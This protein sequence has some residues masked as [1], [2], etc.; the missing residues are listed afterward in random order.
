[1]THAEVIRVVIVDDHPVVREGLRAMLETDSGFDVVGDVGNAVDALRMIEIEHPHVVLT[2][3]RMPEVN[4]CELARRVSALDPDVKVLV[5]TTYD[6]GEDILQAI[7]VGACGYLL[8][9]TPRKVLRDSIRAAARGETVLSPAVASKL[10]SRLRQPPA[11]L[12][13]RETEVL[14]S[15]SSGNTNASIGRQLCISEATVKTHLQHV[16]AK[17]GVDDRTAAV[18]KALQLGLLG[19]PRSGQ[20]S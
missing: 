12:S 5:L 19:D 7:E 14:R 4:G 13:E 15:V 20:R 11:V 16:F 1:M 9:D 2:D 17:L 10:R 8:K 3:L 6:D 18:T